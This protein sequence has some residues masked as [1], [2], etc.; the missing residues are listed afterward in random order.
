MLPSGCVDACPGC[1]YRGLP[2]AE[3]D[4]KKEA[5]ARR[6]LGPSALPIRAPK[7]R[8]GYRRKTLLHAG[9]DER[10]NWTLGL[11]KRKGWDAEL[12]PIPDCPA[13]A[14]E[15]NQLLRSLLPL[16]PSTL[17]LAFVQ[18]SGPLLTLVLK[19]KPSE[20]WRSW[21]KGT[22][23]ELKRAGA[24][25]LQLNWN[26]SA[27]RKAISS[28]HQEII[29]GERF[30]EEDGLLHG[31]LSFRQQIPELENEALEGALQ[32]F[33]KKNLR[34]VLDLY[35]GA[36]ASLA[37][38]ERQGWRCAGVELG[39]EACEAAKRN[40]PGSLVLKGKVEQRLPQLAQF[41]AGESFLV[42]TNP[43]REGMG[44]EV[45]RWLLERGPA[46]IA[47]LSCNPRS[48]AADLA[49]LAPKFRLAGAQ[50]YDFFPRTDHVECLALLEQ[51]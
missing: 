29:F 19:S 23:E 6:W 28:R 37:L 31:A 33:R 10:G 44:E 1:R 38:W 24:A 42:Y 39:G 35:S 2:A 26:P 9:K 5:W 18:A 11:L 43:P 36:G 14:P 46:A 30:V 40:A 4:E 8:L 13:H 25:G 32:F 12:V 20:E 47:Y 49:L 45:C 50:P 22:E 7:T 16:L 34:T 15:L 27:G 3:S 48:Q 41:S 51:V 17:P 21:A